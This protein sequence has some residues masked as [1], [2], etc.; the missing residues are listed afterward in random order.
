MSFIPNQIRMSTRIGG[1]LM[2]LAKTMSFVSIF[3]FILITRIQY[4][5]ADDDFVRTVFPNYTFFLS[6]VI[7]VTLIAMTVIYVFII[8]SEIKFGNQ[9]SVKDGRNPVYNLLEEVKMDVLELKKEISELKEVK[10]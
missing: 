1:F 10:K 5:N 8:P 4:Y 9:Q 3:N 7:I 2:L 6:L